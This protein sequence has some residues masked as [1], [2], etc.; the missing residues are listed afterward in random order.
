MFLEIFAFL[1]FLNEEDLI[2]LVEIKFRLHSFENMKI[3]NA[4][5]SDVLTRR[6]NNFFDMASLHN[7]MLFGCFEKVRPEEFVDR[8][9][10]DEQ[11]NGD[12]NH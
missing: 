8:L 12:G 10:I 11:T 7:H 9:R 5:C 1:K 4:F 2:L 3:V 6:K